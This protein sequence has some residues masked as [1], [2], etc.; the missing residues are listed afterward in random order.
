MTAEDMSVPAAALT[1]VGHYDQPPGYATRRASGAPSWLLMWTQAGAG[2]VEQSGVSF[3]AE[4]G[5]L[6]VLGS[7]AAHHY[8][9]APGAGRWRFWWVHFQ[10]RPS[11]PGWLAPHAAA[12]GCHRVAGVAPALH[13]RIDHAFVRALR[14][15]R[16]LPPP[17]LENGP[18]GASGNS[19]PAALG[20]GPPAVGGGPPVT[21]I[22]GSGAARELVL[23]AVEEVLVLVTASA[24]RGGESGDVRIRRALA[25]IAAEPGAPHSVDS[26]ARAVALSPSRFAHLFTAE[27]GRTPMR[28]L[29]EA[30]LWH[31]ATLLEATDLDIGQVAAASGFVSPFHF[32]RVFRREYG[33]PPR[34]YRAR[35]EYGLPLHDHRPRRE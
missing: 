10:P 34:D 8:R 21:A 33:L 12:P 2:H 15:T 26:L 30:R 3:L 22:A 31:A 5:D 16:W 19:P 20:S 4:P 14:D 23:G 32:S 25:L 29:R 35:R 13:E 28:A 1:I 11:W 18:P 27:T 17:A 6:V 24:R 9:V 7:G